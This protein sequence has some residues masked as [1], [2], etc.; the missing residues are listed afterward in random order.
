M[1]S[2][3]GASN[4]VHIVVVDDEDLFRESL[5]LNLI[6]EGYEVTS[7]AS[8]Q[9]ALNYF[10]TGGTADVVLLDWRMPGMP[11]AI[12]RKRLTRI[13]RGRDF[14]MKS[15]PRHWQARRAHQTGA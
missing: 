8:G 9:S 10:A 13:D 15:N 12:R 5:G 6:D 2:M 11:R 1:T 4:P 3:N 14:S 7:F